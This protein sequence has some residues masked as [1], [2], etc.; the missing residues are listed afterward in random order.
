MLYFCTENFCFR[1]SQLDSVYLFRVF[2]HSFGC[3]VSQVQHVRPLLH[4]AIS[5]LWRVGSSSLTRDPTQAPALEVQSLSHWTSREVPGLSLDNPSFVVNI[6]SVIV[7]SQLN[8]CLLLSIRPDQGI[9][10]SHVTV[11]ELLHSLSNL[12]LVG[13]DI[14]SEY[15]CVVVFCFLHG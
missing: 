10:F 5:Q 8:I 1:I 14:H 7:R 3:A 15:R 13:F 4:P 9:E 11:T 2:D 6:L 12:V